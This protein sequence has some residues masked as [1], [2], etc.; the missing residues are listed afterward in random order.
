[1]PTC[2]GLFTRAVPSD[3]DAGRAAALRLEMERGAV[4]EIFRLNR[5]RCLCS[6]GALLYSDV[7]D[8]DYYVGFRSLEPVICLWLRIL[9]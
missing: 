9:P 3:D 2:G 1:M 5:A 4:I 6:E 7:C 8:R